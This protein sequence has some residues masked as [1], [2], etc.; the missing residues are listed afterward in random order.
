ME[1]FKFIN[2]FLDGSG[3]NKGKKPEEHYSSFDYCYN[4]F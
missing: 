2:Q 4:Y 1:V 3:K